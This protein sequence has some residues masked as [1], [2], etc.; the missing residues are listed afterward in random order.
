MKKLKLG[1]AGLG[2]RGYGMLGTFLLF[3]DVDVV[4]VCDV[5]E[6]RNDR[7]PEKN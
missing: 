6:D 2:Q 1:V 3:A 7:A 4:A 5:Y